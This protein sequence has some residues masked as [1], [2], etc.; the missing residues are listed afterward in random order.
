MV[1]IIS[2]LLLLVAYLFGSIPTGYLMARSLKGIDIREQGSGSTGATNVLR[3]VGKKAALATLLLDMLKGMAAIAMVHLSYA[4]NLGGALPLSWKPWLVTLAGIIAIVGHSKPVW[5]NFK[6]GKSVAASIGVLLVMSPPAALGTIA[7]FA[8]TLWTWRIVS[9][10]SIAGAI[11]VNALMI[12]FN[13]PLPYCLFAAVAGLYVILRHRSNIERLLA[14]TEP[15]IGQK[16]T[17]EVES[18]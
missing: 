6:G 16:V 14:G 8:A 1:W 7:V 4:I 13:E 3:T 11:A 10:G 17:Q 5:L 9:L 2:G 15:S 18:H 12:L